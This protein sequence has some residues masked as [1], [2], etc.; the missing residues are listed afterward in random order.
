VRCDLHPRWSRDG[1]YITVDSIHSGNRGIYA[2]N[3][4]SALKVCDFA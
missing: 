4:E 3:T 2:L 1:R